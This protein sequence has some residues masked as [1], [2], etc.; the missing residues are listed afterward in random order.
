[1][2][3]VTKTIPL[4]TINSLTQESW[5]P[6]VSDAIWGTN[7]WRELLYKM[8]AKQNGGVSVNRTIIF[9]E[10][11]SG[12]Y[13]SLDQLDLSTA[14][15]V[16]T[17]RYPWFQVYAGAAIEWKEELINS[18]AAAIGSVLQTRLDVMEESMAQ[19]QGQALYSD[20][21]IAEMMPGLLAHISTTTAIT[22]GGISASTNL[23]W[24]NV[25]V[26]M[27]GIPLTLFKLKQTLGLVKKGNRKTT[28]IIT[29]QAIHDIIWAQAQAGQRQV[30]TNTATLGFMDLAFEGIPIIVDDHCPA[31]Y[32]FG[33]NI[34][35]IQ[36]YCHSNDDMKLWGWAGPADQMY[37]TN[38]MTWTGGLASKNRRFQFVMYNVTQ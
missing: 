4:D 26:N 8:R 17:A 27:S 18:G 29:T 37:K 6:G 11:P 9:G 34:N 16:T 7:S 21:S 33:V 10:G 12:W 31:G 3:V 5:L 32:L 30:N 15:I 22:I 1:V 38:K 36:L 20:G 23:W 28:H 24:R 35:E 13:S 19:R 25:I 14:D 2:A